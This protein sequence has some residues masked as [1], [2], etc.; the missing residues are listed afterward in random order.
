V[1]AQ[2]HVLVVLVFAITFVFALKP[3]C[4]LKIR[5]CSK[6][7]GINNNFCTVHAVSVLV[8]VSSRL[9]ITSNSLG[10]SEDV[11]GVA[12][13]SN[14]LKLLVFSVAIDIFFSIAI[15]VMIC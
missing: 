12:R 5:Q 13:H 2:F 6:T 15:D 9:C 8:S 4:L 11:A 10:Q 1:L 7:L 3:Y 14:L